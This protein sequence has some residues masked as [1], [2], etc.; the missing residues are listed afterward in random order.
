MSLHFERVS[1]TLAHANYAHVAVLLIR[2]TSD[3]QGYKRNERPRRCAV[4]GARR[5]P[6]LSA[7][8]FHDESW[9]TSFS[10]S[11][12]IRWTS[13]NLEMNEIYLGSRKSLFIC[14]YVFF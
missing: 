9:W 3:Y 1:G 11:L 2:F 4:S 10:V 14:I 5:P 6:P 7:R 12:K 13:V 8:F